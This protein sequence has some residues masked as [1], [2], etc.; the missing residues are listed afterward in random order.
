MPLKRRGQPKVDFADYIVEIETWSCDYHFGVTGGRL[1]DN[2]PYAEYRHVDI[3]GPIIHPT[4]KA[5]TA[6]LCVIPDAQLD[7]AQRDRHEPDG[8]GTLTSYG[9]RLDGYLNIPM[10][11]LL[12]VLQMLGTAKYRYVEM[13]GLALRHRKARIKS[14]R[15]CET[16]E[17]PEFNSE[18]I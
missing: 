16:S 5:T 6:R 14:Y 4:L 1:W 18:A 10:D 13:H 7:R 11:G 8:V 12:V 9:P 2:D 3:T 15:F 17:W